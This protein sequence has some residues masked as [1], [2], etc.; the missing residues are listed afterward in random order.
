MTDQVQSIPLLTLTEAAA[1]QV[2][3]HGRDNDL[4][5]RLAEDEAFAGIDWAGL[6]DVR[7][8]VGRAPEQ[9]DEFLS[10]CVAPVLAR[11][12]SNESDTEGVRI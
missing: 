9:V 4:L 1:E 2:K 12:A 3:L 10:E 11:Y 6:L 8:Y 7:A 5:E